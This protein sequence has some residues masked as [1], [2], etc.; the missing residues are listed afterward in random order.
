MTNFWKYGVCFGLLCAVFAAAAAKVEFPAKLPKGAERNA[1]GNVETAGTRLVSSPFPVQERRRYRLKVQARIKSGNA[2]E[3]VPAME[4]MMKQ[5]VGQ[6]LKTALVR[7]EYRSE[8]KVLSTMNHANAL[9]IFSTQ[10][11]EYLLEFYTL[12]GTDAVRVLILPNDPKNTVEVKSMEIV[13]VDMEREKYLNVN[14]D[15]K[16]GPYNLCGHGGGTPATFD[17]DD[18]GPYLDVGT[19]WRV[20]DWIPVNPGDRLKFSW[21]GEPA[22]GRA[23]RI[24]AWYY[25]SAR[26]KSPVT[27]QSKLPMRITK[28]APA[29]SETLVVPEKANWMRLIIQGGLL[30]YIR[31]EKIND[32]K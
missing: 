15:L 25:Q 19:G 10:F 14:P 32:A 6:T 4:Q 7:Y 26:A 2:L 12:D 31:V 18:A 27:A 8:N 13:P 29:G 16:F 9:R 23:M 22:P 28:T 30:R 11:R 17:E 20:G 5:G 3:T 1:E 24:K 21:S